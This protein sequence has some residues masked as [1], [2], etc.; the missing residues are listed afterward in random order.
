MKLNLEGEV[1]MGDLNEKIFV[2][3]R[4][5]MHKES[6]LE[7][8]KNQF[9]IISKFIRKVKPSD[10]VWPGLLQQ[11]LKHLSHQLNENIPQKPTA[12]KNIS[13]DI[14][15]QEMLAQERVKVLRR[16]LSA[17]SYRMLVSRLTKYVY[18][19]FKNNK[20]N[21]ISNKDIYD[22]YEFL[23]NLNLSSIT[24]SQYIIA[25]RKIFTF[26][27]ANEY[28]FR[29]PVFPK[30]KNTSTPRGAFSLD[31]YRLLLRNAKKL[32]IVSKKVS[33]PTHRDKRNGIFT[34]IDQIPKEF[35]WLIGFMTNSFVRPVDIKLIQHQ[36]IQVI[37]SDRVYLRITLPETKRHTSQIVTLSSAVRIYESLF[38]YMQSID[39]AAPEDYLFLPHI[40][41]RE[42]AIYII[43]KQFRNL[44][45]ET[46]IRKG[47][48][49]QNRTLYSLRHTAITF[50]LLYGKG[51]DLLTLARN[52]RTSV[53]MIERFYTSNL[54]PEMNIE[55]LQSRRSK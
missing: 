31:E 52:A 23:R 25:L 32:S 28:I 54:S 18:P 49:G 43:G 42:A 50:R 19:F 37:R 4:L 34:E 22:F 2:Q 44:L 16:E 26:A 46:G 51:I 21:T 20:I 11:Q 7:L 1:V 45:E 38:K 17:Q 35:V 27:L 53:E 6:E 10:Q 24:I 55:M 8:P 5:N 12:L 47:L 13:V 29:M 36:H 40:K 14:L 15:G 9:K 33:I 41:D 48:L 3:D 39:F 30:I